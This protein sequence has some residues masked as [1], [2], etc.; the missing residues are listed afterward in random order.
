MKALWAD[1]LRCPR[2]R[3][4]LALTSADVADDKVWAGVLDC[5]SCDVQTPIVN[6]V[7]DLL[8]EPPLRVRDEIQGQIA[9]RAGDLPPDVARRRAEKYRALDFEEFRQA[10]LESALAHIRLRP[11]MT[12]LDLGAGD[13][14][15]LPILAG[16]GLH[17]LGID[18]LY[19]DDLAALLPLG[20]FLKADL[21][22]PPLQEDSF[23]LVITSAALHH[24]Y[25]LPSAMRHIAR[26]L[27]P[28]G[29]FLA[30]SEPT[31]GLLKDNAR[32]G[33][34]AHPCLN[35]HVYWIWEYLRLARQVGLRPRTYLPGYVSR[36][37]D[38]GATRG[39]R[40]GRLGAVVASFW[41]IRW[42]RKLLERYGYLPASLLFGMPMVMVAQR[43]S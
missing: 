20:S 35:E 11:G 12:A 15:L 29:L 9:Q 26:L 16:Y 41:Q 42:I 28:G 19:P 32:Y 34:D 14:W 43:E 6:G 39:L 18:V 27:K 7:V 25:D 38:A 36:R 40:F 4:R 2:C 3:G 23:D 5:V 8:L 24:A 22:D 30:I 13:G 1:L 31:K 33:C 37:L 17:Y 10:N 21:N